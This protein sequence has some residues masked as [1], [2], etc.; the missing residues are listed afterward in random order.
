MPLPHA[1][2]MIDQQAVACGEL[3]SP[4]YEFLLRRAALDVAAGGPCAAAIAGY[5]QAPGPD[6]IALRLLGGVHA[7][8]LTGRAPALAAY[9]PSAGGEFTLPVPEAAWTAFRAT[10]AEHLDWVRTWLTRP[11]QTNETGRANLLIAGLLH[12]SADAPLPVRLFELGA[13]AGLNLLADRF[14]CEW[15]GGAHGPAD[16]PVRLTDAWR[17]DPVFRSDRPLPDL[18]FTE[19]RGCDLTPI[20]P[21]SPEG[22]L[23]LRAYVWADRP[24]RAARLDGALAL[25]AKHSAPVERLGAAEFLRRVSVAEGTLTVVWHSIMRQYVPADEWALVET[26]LARLADAATPTAPFAHIA[27]EPHRVAGSDQ[28]RFVLT[29][30]TGTAPERV[31]AEAVPHGLPAW[32]WS[33]Q[34]G[35]PVG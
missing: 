22:A 24:E 23:A 16:S 6:A 3:G 21:L 2:A 25:A 20:D 27:F 10:V 8:V 29:V 14:R 7:L 34:A 19:R 17:G 12:L 9:Y 30:R 28:R 13:S 31:L 15:S 33:E 5:E 26:E 18:E 35:L 32:A 11:P 1:A 4:L